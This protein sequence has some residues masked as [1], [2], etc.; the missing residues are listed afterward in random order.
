M[1]SQRNIEIQIIWKHKGARL[2]NHPVKNDKG[3]P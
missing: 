2:L 1:F 3:F